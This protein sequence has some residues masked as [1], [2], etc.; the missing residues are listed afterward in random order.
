M[1]KKMEYIFKITEETGTIFY[2]NKLLNLRMDEGV[3]YK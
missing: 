3:V 1:Q 2:A